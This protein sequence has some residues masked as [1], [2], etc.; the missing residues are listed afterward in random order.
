LILGL[1]AFSFHT[2]C[3]LQFSWFSWVLAA[4]EGYQ[5]W[6]F[7]SDIPLTDIK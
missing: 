1:A 3:Q 6:D 2:G 4:A 7:D 5:L